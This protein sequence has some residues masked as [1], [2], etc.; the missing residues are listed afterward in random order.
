[1]FNDQA[2]QLLGVTADELAKMLPNGEMP[3]GDPPAQFEDVFSRANFQSLA[4]TL[5]CNV[6]QYGD[7]E[8]RLKVTVQRMKTIDWAEESAALIAAIPM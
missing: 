5:R 1:M 8:A 4:S 3:E 2:E 7:G 6:E